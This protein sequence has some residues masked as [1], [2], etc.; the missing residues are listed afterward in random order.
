MKPILKQSSSCTR[1][2][3]RLFDSI[4]PFSL[5]PNYVNNAHGSCLVSLGRTQVICSATIDEKVPAFLRNSNTGWVTAEY[6]MLPASTQARNQRESVRGKQS[7]RTQ[8][9]QRLI[10]R[11]LRAAVDLKKLGSRQIIV[12]CD[13]INADGGTRTAS[14]SGGFVAMFLALSN[15]PFL[16][17]AS[18]IPITKIV[19]G[20]SCGIVDDAS[21][22]D[23]DYR[24]DSSAMVDANFVMDSKGG[25]IESQVTGEDGSFSQ[26]DLF[27][28]FLLA[29]AGI[30][31]IITHQR[32]MLDKKYEF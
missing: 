23:L 1:K 4:R 28:L 17:S 31:K 8:E 21:V 19:A 2:D 14:I 16:G 32:K 18:K 12:D 25:I 27:D 22:L 15:H 30:D 7:G 29:R 6:S 26:G 3:G 5:K 24:E 13:V 10:G 11:S 20:I 9:I